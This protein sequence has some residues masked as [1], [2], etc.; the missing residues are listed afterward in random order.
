MS[1]ML[2]APAL[3][4]SEGG[5]ERMMRL[6][7]RALDENPS[8]HPLTLA[9][10]NDTAADR[11]RLYAA[12]H[13]P[14]ARY[15]P[16]NRSRVAFA[17]R[18]LLAARSCRTLICGHLHLW[19]L[20]GFAG[21]VHPRLRTFLITHGIEAWRPW[22]FAEQRAAVGATA[23]IAVSTYTRQRVVDRLSALDQPPP[24]LVVPN[25][26]DPE[27]AQPL[28]QPKQPGLIVTL[29]RLDSRD[30]YKGID[31][32]IE[33]VARAQHTA[34]HIRLCIM[35]DGPDA[36]RLKQLCARQGARDVEFTGHL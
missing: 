35:G 12:T 22:S 33:A 3:F 16:G 34:P 17:L 14:V 2:L 26:L 9:T 13:A 21:R 15:L 29:A 18:V 7:L 19:P 8:A 36:P 10:L 5:I 4:A 11:S 27:Q 6:Y 31:H 30:T 32:L 28:E 24:V 25:C 1:T 20:A 23:I